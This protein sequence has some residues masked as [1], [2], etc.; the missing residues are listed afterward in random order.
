MGGDTASDLN[1]SSDAASGHLVS[2]YFWPVPGLQLKI[3]QEGFW[4]LADENSRANGFPPNPEATQ[5]LGFD[6]TGCP[7]VPHAGAHPTP[8]FSSSF[9]LR[10]KRE[11]AFS[12]HPLSHF[13]L[14]I[15]VVRKVIDVP[16]ITQQTRIKARI[17]IRIW[18]Y[19]H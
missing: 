14:T 13:I 12:E 18:V 15:T 8:F 10:K 2:S 1:M 6:L 5:I 3:I 4:V 7:R 16:E 17:G 11:P 19:L 9:C